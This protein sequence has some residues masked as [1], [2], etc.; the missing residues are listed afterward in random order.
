MRQLACQKSCGSKSTFEL[1]SRDTHVLLGGEQSVNLRLR[2]PGAIKYTFWK[3]GN[4]LLHW[5]LFQ[6]GN[7][8]VQGGHRHFS[9]QPLDTPV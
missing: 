3:P 9:V 4:S 6:T 1:H 5:G 7:T 2:L 8:L